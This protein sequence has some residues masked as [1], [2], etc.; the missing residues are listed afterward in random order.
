V[1]NFQDEFNFKNEP[2]KK[3]VICEACGKKSVVYTYTFA[4]N[5][6]AVL[7]KLYLANGP[8]KTDDLNLTYAQRTNSQ[9]LRY[10]GLAK[11]FLKSDEATQKRG[12]WEITDKGRKFVEGLTSIPKKATVRD[13]VV[14]E[15]SDDGIMFYEVDEGY[16]FR[17]YYQGVASDQIQAGKHGG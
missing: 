9:K 14:I 2:E 11:P 4:K 7:E 16:K 15:L 10:W 1:N 6:A 13:N 17:S 8:A 3:E 12:W 5:H